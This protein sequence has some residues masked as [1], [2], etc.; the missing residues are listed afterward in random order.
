MTTVLGGGSWGT[1]LAWLLVPLVRIDRIEA[2][3]RAAKAASIA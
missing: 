3:A 2:T 1:A